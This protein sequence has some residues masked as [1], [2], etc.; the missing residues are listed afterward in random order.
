MISFCV[1]TSLIIIWFQPN[2]VYSCSIGPLGLSSY[3]YLMKLPKSDCLICFHPVTS[4]MITISPYNYSL[5]ILQLH[6]FSPKT[7]FHSL[8]HALLTDCSLPFFS[9]PHSFWGKTY[10]LLNFFLC[11]L[12]TYCLCLTTIYHCMQQDTVP[13]ILKILGVL[14]VYKKP[15]V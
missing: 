9:S 1:M 15:G 5:S 6:S 4:L 12:F 2:F 13:E 8:S 11:K 10:L 7:Q 3:K 14:Q